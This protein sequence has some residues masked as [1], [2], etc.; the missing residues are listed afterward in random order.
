MPRARPSTSCKQSCMLRSLCNFQAVWTVVQ[1]RCQ[2][3][4]CCGACPPP[5]LHS[6]M[7]S[8]GNAQALV[9]GKELNSHQ[10]ETP[11]PPHRLSFQCDS[12][13][14]HALP[15]HKV[16]EVSQCKGDQANKGCIPLL[17]CKGTRRC[18]NA[19]RPEAAH[20]PR[21]RSAAPHAPCFSNA[22]SVGAWSPFGAYSCIMAT[23]RKRSGPAPSGP[24]HFE[25][26]A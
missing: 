2:L 20:R 16:K 17:A 3:P 22:T 12:A 11:R 10:H 9:C 19:S 1:E 24:R 14:Q 18:E 7:S 4:A 8:D 23:S 13:A 6:A 5:R 15:W 21:R 25:S 26:S